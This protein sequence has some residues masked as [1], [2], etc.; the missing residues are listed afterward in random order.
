MQKI[1][2][3][4][5]V[6]F[7]AFA[8][9]TSSSS[10]Q[11]AS[12]VPQG[13]QFVINLRM[14]PP[15]LNP[16]SSTTVA[17]GFIFSYTLDTLL[18][19]DADTYEW[20]PRVAEKWDVS[21]DGL[22]FTFYLNKKAVF[23]DGEPL[24]ADDVKFSFDMI[25]DPKFG[26]A[27]HRVA[28]EAMD[29]AEVVDPHTVKFF[30]KRKY[31]RNLM[32]LGMLMVLPKHIYSVPEKIK[33]VNKTVFGSGPYVIDS[34]E[35]TRRMVLKKNPKWF[36]WTEPGFKNWYNFDK[37]IFR[38]ASEPNV[39]LEMLR[40]GDIDF[41]IANADV[42]NQNMVGRDFDKK[43]VK[44]KSDSQ[45]SKPLSFLIWN[46]KNELFA[47]KNV[48]I[49]LAHLMNRE[50]INKKLLY[51]EGL[52][53]TGPFHVSSEFAP[54][55]IKPLKYDPA[56]A[57]KLLAQAGWSD[58]DKDGVLD[59]KIN[60]VKRNFSFTVLYSRKEMEKFYTFYKEDL[61]KAGIELLLK[62]MDWTAL[63][64]LMD[65]YKFDA[66]A[67]SY[68]LGLDWDPKFIWHSASYV[69]GGSNVGGYANSQVDRWIDEARE[70]LDRPKR[71]QILRKV[72]RQ[73]SED[74]PY[75]FMFDQ[76]YSYYARSK[77]VKVPKDS[78]KYDVGIQYWWAEDG[79]G[80]N[81]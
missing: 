58:S 32:N 41:Q 14:E 68:Q 21:K 62:Q 69:P 2:F 29:R 47:N 50:E 42:M 20:Q 25:F 43:I 74:A 9:A 4:L 64:K 18:E 56:L 11:P 60:G 37:I 53:S 71:V 44:V 33:N 5:Y 3:F 36:G 40:R 66:V 15:T 31:F 38:F 72:Y 45:E 1:V 23:A 12:S 77:R 73:I 57:A 79:A 67:M 51:G 19:R 8:N 49:A 27:H 13:G 52:L 76:K 80:R 46:L 16:A 30:A 63:E 35:K 70:T 65:E 22:V 34:Y 61:R 75:L 59:K 6:F 54:K 17:A 78:F 24:T 26:N 10:A 28:W 81:P 7:A 48:R 55:D 39:Y